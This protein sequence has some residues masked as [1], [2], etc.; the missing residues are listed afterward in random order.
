MGESFW[1]DLEHC[2]EAFGFINGRVST[3]YGIIHL[4]TGRELTDTILGSRSEK[5]LCCA[6]SYE[7]GQTHIEFESLE[8]GDEGRARCAFYP[9]VGRILASETGGSF[10]P[11]LFPL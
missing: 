4:P 3:E 10:V 9:S 5:L 11:P 6:F 2:A 1:L 7:G 8:T